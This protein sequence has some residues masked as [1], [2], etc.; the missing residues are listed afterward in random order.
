V[1]LS[2]VLRNVENQDCL[3]FFAR[4]ITARKN[5]EVQ[6]REQ[7]NFLGRLLDDSVDGI[8]AFDLD[9]ILTFCTPSLERFLGVNKS[10]IIGKKAWDALPFLEELGEDL[11]FYEAIDG[12]KVTSRNRAYTIPGSERRVTFDVHYSPLFSESGKVVGGA[13]VFRDMTET[14]E[15]ERALDD[16]RQE[17]DAQQSR[18]TAAHGEAKERLERELED[19]RQELDAQKSRVTEAHEEVQKILERDL[20]EARKELETQKS[21]LIAV[22]GE[23]QKKLEHEIDELKSTKETLQESEEALRALVDSIPDSV[24]TVNRDGQ[25]VFFNRVWPVSDEEQVV[26]ADFYR[27]IRPECHEALRNGLE[28][29]FRTKEREKLELVA[30]SGAKYE[31]RL[32]PL[33]RGGAMVGALIVSTEVTD[34]VVMREDEAEPVKRVLPEHELENLTVVAGGVVRDYD[35]LLTNMLGHTGSV[36]EELPPDSTARYSL[37]QIETAALTATELTEQL[38]DYA[39]T[40]LP[41]PRLLDLGR[42][43]DEMAHDL[44]MAVHPDALLQKQ[45]ADAPLPI[46]ADAGQLR[47]LVVSLVR[48][49]SEAL[50]AQEGIV[51][52]TTGAVEAS[53]ADL[54]SCYLGEELPE[55]SYA[56]L[57]VSDTGEGMDQETLAKAFVPF[58][59]TKTEG[60]GL[61]LARVVGT[62]RRHHGAIEMKSTPLHGTSVRVLFPQHGLREVTVIE[63]KGRSRSNVE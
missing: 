61:G 46:R 23:A 43:V 4:D 17:L 9:C 20:N 26:A 58:F 5:T 47:Q 14:R 39:E 3:V 12:K 8:L 19:A 27:L 42:L 33:M 45:T 54:S 31:A 30:A 63:E 48:N 37:E 55:G 44:E 21:Q 41:N 62:V 10:E 22:H 32:V 59:T 28:Q 7:V 38:Q 29:V 53:R 2:I 60:G 35:E 50:A 16:A 18:L 15:T 13:A 34:D 57:E 56:Y 25:I 49:A 11:Y 40:D 51:T 36:L 6:L 52:V 1:D 24:I